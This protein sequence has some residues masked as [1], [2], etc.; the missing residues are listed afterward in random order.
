MACSHALNDLMLFLP[1]QRTE[2]QLDNAVAPSTPVMCSGFPFLQKK[3]LYFTLP[4]LHTMNGCSAMLPW[5]CTALT[6]CIALGAE[7]SLNMLGHGSSLKHMILPGVRV[8]RQVML[9]MMMIAVLHVVI[10]GV[11]AVACTRMLEGSRGRHR[12]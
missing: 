1:G 3:P 8:C 9:V 7:Y 10:Q 4:S 12:L 5:Y 2:S 11:G 6:A